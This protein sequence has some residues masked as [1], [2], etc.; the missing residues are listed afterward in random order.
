MQKELNEAEELENENAE[1]QVSIEHT[2][3]IGLLLTYNRRTSTRWLWRN[4]NTHQIN[5]KNFSE[6]VYY[7]ALRFMDIP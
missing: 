3:L 6:P 2:T 1:L 5:T 7:Q 4:Y